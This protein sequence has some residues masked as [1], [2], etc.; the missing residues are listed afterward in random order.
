[1]TAMNLSSIP[2]AAKIGLPALGV[3]ALA[4]GAAAAALHFSGSASGAPAPASSSPVVSSPAPGQGSNKKVINDAMLQA[5]AQVLAIDRKTLATDL[6]QG[7]TVQQLATQ[8]GISQ[9]QFQAKLIQDVKPLLD[10]DVNQGTLTSAQEQTTMSRLSRS[11]PHWNQAA[12][13]RPSQSPRQ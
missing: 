13:P 4:G 7:A 2:L 1:M 5:E 9:S 6:K 12:R 10:Q 3:L 11:I 8:A